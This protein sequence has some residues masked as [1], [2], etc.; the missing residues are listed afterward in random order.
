PV[1]G[2]A[3]MVAITVILAAAIGSSVLG[4]KTTGFAPQANIDLRAGV[5]CDLNA[6]GGTNESDDGVPATV[7]F[8]HMGGDPINFDDEGAGTKVLV[9]INGY[10]EEVAAGSLDTISIG[11]TK[12]LEL[13]IFNADH[14]GPENYD[15]G[16]IGNI[17]Q[18]AIVNLKIIDVETQQLILDKNVRF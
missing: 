7:I 1:I 10:S 2:V 5:T 11:D 13:K 9:T 6:D 8:E 4:Q 14:D 16:I 17:V 12:T 3:L 15:A 18:G